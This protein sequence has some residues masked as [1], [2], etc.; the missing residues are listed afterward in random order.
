M[1]LIEKAIDRVGKGHNRS[2]EPAAPV[3]EKHIYEPVSQVGPIPEI[4]SDLVNRGTGVSPS[5]RKESA[6]RQSDQQLVQ[7]R[8]VGLKL[9]R[10]QAMGLLTTDTANREIAEEFRVIKRP[11]LR[12]AFEQ[13][14]LPLDHG[15]LVMVTSAQP[16]EG[17]TF[18]SIS[19]AVS[20]AMEFDRT[21]LLVDTDLPKPSIGRV[22]DLGDPLPGL[23]D[24]LLDG[25]TDLSTFL[26]KTEIPKL[27]ILPAGS[28]HPNA[29]ELLASQSMKELTNQLS[30]RYRDRIVIFD[31]PPLLANSQAAALAAYMGQ[32]LVVVEASRTPQL[33]LK[34]A[35]AL[36][37]SNKLVGLVLNKAK[38]GWIW[39]YGYSSSYGYCGS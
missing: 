12:N 27:N 3:P 23:V 22:L 39:S 10:M 29:T 26:L 6:L 8:R 18:I 4:P 11:L 9:D 1:S 15:N 28:H 17:K 14:T 30:L 36:L 33:V 7:P 16:S 25:K 35:L 38:R 34:E 24:Y 32:I 37:D 2:V 13:A 5:P 20:I 31:S 19:L 21:V